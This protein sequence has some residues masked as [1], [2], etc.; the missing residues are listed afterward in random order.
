MRQKV[1][2][3][4]KDHWG[5]I[6]RGAVHLQASFLSEPWI[7]S[8][9]WLFSTT[10][11]NGTR[12]RSLREERVL[13]TLKPATTAMHLPRRFGETSVNE[14]IA[15][16]VTGL[17]NW[18]L[19]QLGKLW[20]SYLSTEVEELPSVTDWRMQGGRK[21]IS[22]SSI[23]SLVTPAWTRKPSGQ[24][25]GAQL[26]G[27]RCTAKRWRGRYTGGLVFAAM[28]CSSVLLFCQKFYFLF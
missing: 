19:A 26:E 16:P 5:S 27:S 18:S 28:L 4:S 15:K 25:A 1:R 9:L 7:W 21:W 6:L 11:P 14:C 20:G 3:V 8:L 10:H 12:K 17:D 2:A 22:I 24:G 23:N 13:F